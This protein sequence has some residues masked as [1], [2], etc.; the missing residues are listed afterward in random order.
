MTLGLQIIIISL[1]V[2][3]LA[4]ILKAT[5]QKKISESHALL[6]IVPCFLIIFGGIFPQITYSL[7]EL[8][9]TGYPPALVFS[10]AIIFSYLILFQSFKQLSVLSRRNKELA[11]QV[12]LLTA[13]VHTLKEE[14]EESKAETLAKQEAALTEETRTETMKKIETAAKKKPR[15]KILFVMNTMGRAGAERAL[16]ALINTLPKEEYDISLQVL[17]NRGEI[18]DEIP[19]HVK[20]LNKHP[21]NRSVLSFGGKIALIKTTLRC[22]FYRLRGFKLLGYLCRNLIIQIKQH[23]FAPDKLL[24]R[25]IANGTKAPKE[26]FDLAVAYLEGGSTYFV[27]DFVRA[28]KTASFLHIDYQKAGYGKNLDLD[29]YSRITRIFSVS[30]EAGESFCQVYPEYR[31][32]VYLF[33]NIIN[34]DWIKQMSQEELPATDPF[35]QSNAKYKL[36]TVGRLNYQKAYDIAIPALR[37]LRDHGFD[38]DWFILGEGPLEKELRTQIRQEGLE[39]HF[40]LL[41]SQAN[42][43][44]YYLQATLYIHATRFEG[45]SIAIE[46]AQVLGKAIVASDC[47]GNREQIENGVSGYLV[48]LNPTAVAEHIEQLL[49]DPQKCRQ[50]EKASAGT[51]LKHPED[52]N[53]FLEL[54]Y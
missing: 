28:R 26:F 32:K 33:R 17:I 14:L 13:Q 12:A 25:I 10:L 51:D 8:F 54:L 1:G 48:S 52:M 36:L 27:S 23:Q 6:W 20:L 21:D 11:S 29:A 4:V 19:S 30:K 42:P 49:S 47:T 40:I 5:I 22:F 7:A 50:F 34:T 16:I 38:A 31:E 53:A 9:H 37:L 44:P 2:L 15:K 39:E 41:G 18:F 24:W 43:Y 35:I 46:E 45:K 3:L